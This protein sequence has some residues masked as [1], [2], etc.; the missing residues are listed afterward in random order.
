MLMNSRTLHHP[1][2]LT[3]M[4]LVEEPGRVIIVTNYV[5]GKN[6]FDLLHSDEKV[7]L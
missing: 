6:L 3:F 2:I 5:E 7:L 4:G 1:N